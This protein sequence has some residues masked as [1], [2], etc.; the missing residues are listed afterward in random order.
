MRFRRTNIRLPAP[1]YIGRR[2]FFLTLCCE[3]RNHALA[4]GSL[5]RRVIE[6]L[7]ETARRHAFVVHA[8][9]LMPDHLHALVEGRDV[10]SNCLNF[11]GHFK[12]QTTVLFRQASPCASL[13][14]KKF[15]D[16]I[17]RGRDPLPSVAAYIWMNPVRQ[18]I[19][20]KP[21]DYPYSGSFVVDWTKAPQP[22]SAWTPPWKLHLAA[23]A[24]AP[25]KAV[26]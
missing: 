5:A 25:N 8:Y 13:W 17:L 11:V 4:D 15:Y 7:R 24:D 3:N 12:R 14:Q 22:T 23:T 9:C 18:G 10:S 16:H 20:S 2:R 26:L 19:V 1:V 21:E 6:V